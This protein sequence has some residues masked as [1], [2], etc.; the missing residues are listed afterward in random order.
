MS[1]TSVFL[2]SISFPPS[3]FNL[4]CVPKQTFKSGLKIFSYTKFIPSSQG[5][6]LLKIMLSQNLQIISA[7]TL[8]SNAQFY[9]MLDDRVAAL[10]SAWLGW[11]EYA[12][13]VQ[14]CCPKGQAFPL[15][16]GVFIKPSM[17][18]VCWFSN[19]KTEWNRECVCVC[20]Y[21]YS[22]MTCRRRIKQKSEPQNQCGKEKSE[23]SGFTHHSR[24]ETR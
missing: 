11:N 20:V 19:I 23:R 16:V 7:F 17:C 1:Y 21:I 14:W 18:I 22:S 13:A 2:I 4:F 15:V 6:H 24:H 12:G 9:C 3:P 8:S 10:H 5:F